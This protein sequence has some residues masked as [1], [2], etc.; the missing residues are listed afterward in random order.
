M[1][2][3]GQRAIGAGVSCGVVDVREEGSLRKGRKFVTRGGASEADGVD[4]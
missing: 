2:S 4:V 1:D 3:P